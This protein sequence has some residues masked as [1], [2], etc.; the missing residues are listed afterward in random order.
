MPETY[1]MNSR[2]SM[3]ELHR[4]HRERDDASMPMMSSYAPRRVSPQMRSSGVSIVDFVRA[5]IQSCEKYSILD[6]A[7]HIET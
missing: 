2:H 5:P 1:S 6:G 4:S 7:N 3:H